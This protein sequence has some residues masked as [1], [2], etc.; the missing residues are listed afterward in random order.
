MRITDA[1]GKTLNSVYLALSDA[2]AKELSQALADLLTAEK[3][4][5][6]HISDPTYEREVSVYREDDDTA[7]I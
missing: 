2:E 1:E 5:H 3:G 7:A 4:W 6:G